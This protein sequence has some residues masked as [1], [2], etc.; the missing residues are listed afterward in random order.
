MAKRG[1]FTQRAFLSGRLDLLQAEGVID[2]IESKSRAGLKGA[3]AALDRKVSSRT[4][5]ISN[6]L[7]DLL[8]DIEACIDF[9][10]DDERPFPEILEPLKSIAGNM[11]DMIRASE[12]ARPRREGVKTVIV[13]K[14]NVGKSTLFNGFLNEDRAIVT[15][16]P[17]AT[18]DTID[19]YLNVGDK[20]VLLTDTAGVRIDP[21]P[22]EAEG[23][24]R[25][26]KKI[27]EA[28]IVLLI[29]DATAPLDQEDERLL[30]LTMEKPGLVVL[31]K[32]DKCETAPPSGS[33][34][35]VSSKVVVGISALTGAGMDHL[36]QALDDLASRLLSGHDDPED[37][38][39]NQRAAML[40]ES[41]LGYVREPLEKMEE[42]RWMAPELVAFSL[43][44]ALECLEEITGERVE[45]GILERIFERFCV[46]K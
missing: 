17:G 43:N 8:A 34:E 27:Q 12:I 29:L 38:A 5:Q 30:E 24:A 41:S 40:M 1:E 16:L 44:R 45:E 20:A 2:L 23:I 11:E 42:G 46:G 18:R 22:I 13:G 3:R 10:E 25:T 32:I 35:R 37:A 9:D 21:E 6:E 31:N 4:R 28:D 15:P 36:H 26:L 14:P 19:E 7:K 39:L 33:I